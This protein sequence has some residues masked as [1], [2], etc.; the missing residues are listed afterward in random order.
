[1]KH[2]MDRVN[3]VVHKA[4]SNIFLR[5]MDL[6][7]NKG[8][9]ITSVKTAK[10]LKHA[11]VYFSIMGLKDDDIAKEEEKLNQIS[12]K[13]Q[14]VLRNNVSLKYTPD[15]HFT[16]DNTTNYALKLDQIFKKIDRERCENTPNVS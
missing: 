6:T 16:Y 9:V 10:D 4:L 5:D 14:K 2:R 12:N 1:M 8:V 11:K 15:L 7:Q 3:Q 13:I